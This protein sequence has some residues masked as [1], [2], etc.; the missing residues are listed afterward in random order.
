MT[1]YPKHMI[2]SC[3]HS[4]SMKLTRWWLP[5]VSLLAVGG[6]IAIYPF[7]QQS[8]P[9]LNRDRRPFQAAERPAPQVQNPSL[10]KPESASSD[11]IYEQ[12]KPA[13]VTVYGAYGLG[14][15][16][17][18]RSPGL[19]LTNKHIVDNFATVKVKM[20]D[21]RLYEGKVVDFDLRYDLALIQIQQPNLKLPTVTL[22]NAVNLTKGDRV[23]AIGSPGG[24]AG[25]LTQGTFTRITEHGS[26]QTSSG[27]LQPGN[28]GGPLL[29]AQGQ[30]IGVNKGLLPD[31]SGLATPVTVVQP[32]LQRYERIHGEK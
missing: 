31:Q 1:R 14:A 17:I 6:G 20:S 22:A 25:T 2:R 18:L 15:G 13:I 29:N 23:Y 9:F 26:L 8:V 24:H 3:V 12:V 4:A 7:L 27:L 28:S 16:M 19:V 10:A 30:V 5:A 21:T 32:L 11:P